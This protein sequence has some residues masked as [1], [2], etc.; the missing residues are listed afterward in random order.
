VVDAWRTLER[1]GID[2]I[3]I[4]AGTVCAVEGI[5]RHVREEI[6]LGCVDGIPSAAMVAAAGGDSG[7]AGRLRD[8]D[9]CHHLQAITD[10]VLVVTIYWYLSS[11]NLSCS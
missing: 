10:N 11:S 7:A 9:Y 5:V 4:R 2:E 1:G 3:S 8:K 6:L